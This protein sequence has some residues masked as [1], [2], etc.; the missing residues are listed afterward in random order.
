MA[1]FWRGT[2]ALQRIGAPLETRPSS[3]VLLP[4]NLKSTVGW[5]RGRRP[6]LEQGST[7]EHLMAEQIL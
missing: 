5:Y 1:L 2:V 4:T 6:R 3:L 7:V